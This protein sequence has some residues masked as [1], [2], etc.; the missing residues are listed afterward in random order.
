MK[1]IIFYLI[2]CCFCFHLYSQNKE[3]KSKKYKVWVEL[4][5]KTMS[6]GYL[7][8][9]KDSVIVIVNQEETESME[10]PVSKIKQLKFRR[11]GKIGRSLAIG[12]GTGL[13]VGAIVGY[14]S[15]DD[16]PGFMSLSAEDKSFVLG[17]MALPIGVGIGAI[18]GV[19]KSKYDISGELENYN[20]QRFELN[21]YIFS[22]GKEH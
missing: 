5:D 9:L 4:N 3:S 19:T 14:A 21:K 10:L 22:Y 7:T 13:V 12:A 20:R 8:E 18:V 6:K 15:G 17:T 1:N 11:K 16:E 2:L